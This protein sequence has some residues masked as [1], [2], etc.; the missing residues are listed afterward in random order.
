[1]ILLGTDGDDLIRLDAAT[2][3]TTADGAVSP[4]RVESYE[5]KAGEG[6]DIVTVDFGGGN[7]PRGWT[8]L[9]GQGQAIEAG[10][11][12]AARLDHSKQRADSLR[13]KSGYHRI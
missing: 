7:D 4:K 6:D 11:A 9:R 2:G 1:V 3:F 12:K 13:P 5:V 8:G 10:D